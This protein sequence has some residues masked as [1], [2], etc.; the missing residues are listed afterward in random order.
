MIKNF[1]QVR[2]LRNESQSAKTDPVTLIINQTAEVSGS[3]HLIVVRNDPNKR[4]TSV[5]N[6]N[7]QTMTESTIGAILGPPTKLVVDIFA[8][9][10]IYLIRSESI[11]VMELTD[12]QTKFAVREKPVRFSQ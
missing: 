8:S 6:L 11:E 2:T 7:L 5:A 9:R 3:S 12:D 4:S 1:C 10:E